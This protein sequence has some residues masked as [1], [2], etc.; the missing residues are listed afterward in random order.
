MVRSAQG[1]SGA[2]PFIARRGRFLV[3]VL[4]AGVALLSGC[5]PDTAQVD[6]DGPAQDVGATPDLGSKPDISGVLTDDRGDPPGELQMTDLVEGSGERAGV[7]DTVTVH[8]VGAAWS[9]GVQFDASWDRDQTYTFTVGAGEVIEGWDR[10]VQG[11]RVGGRRSLVIPPE[12]AYGDRGA[13]SAI[14]PG[15]TLAFIVDLLEIE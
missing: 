15:E 9:S 6:E 11:M 3:A 2:G 1:P 8:Y 12:Q 4:L 5:S 10:G 7:G 13:G 14:P